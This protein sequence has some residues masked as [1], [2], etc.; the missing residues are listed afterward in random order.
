M[1]RH[2]LVDR[3]HPRY[4]GTRFPI[5]P[6]EWQ[7]E[8]HGDPAYSHWTPHDYTYGASKAH[9]RPEVNDDEDRSIPIKRVAPKPRPKKKRKRRIQRAVEAVQP[10]LYDDERGVTMPDD[11]N[12]DDVPWWMDEEVL[13]SR[14]TDMLREILE[15][16]Q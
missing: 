9:L 12:P 14:N 2:T 7:D 4:V 6:P 11:T 5:A 3:V 1:E 15:D 10:L 8:G 13:V 16:S